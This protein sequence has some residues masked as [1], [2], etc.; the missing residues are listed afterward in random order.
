MSMKAATQCMGIVSVPTTLGQWINLLTPKLQRSSGPPIYIFIV[1][2]RRALCSLRV[3][4]GAG[5]AS[6]DP[7]QQKTFWIIQGSK[8]LEIQT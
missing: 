3:I 7:N 5:G 6:W 4:R 2:T 1:L 8:S